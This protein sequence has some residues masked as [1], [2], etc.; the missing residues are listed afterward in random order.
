MRLARLNAL[1]RLL[2]STTYLSRELLYEKLDYANCRTLERDIAYL[3]D[4]FGASIRW[5]YEHKGYVLESSGTFMMH[6][7]LS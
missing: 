1:L 5:N 2:A 6:L 7:D 4:T 3:R